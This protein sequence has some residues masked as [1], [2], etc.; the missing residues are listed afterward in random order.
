MIVG[1]VAV[2]LVF[3]SVVL[4]EFRI[5]GFCKAATIE[6]TAYRFVPW[7][8]AG[9]AVLAFWIAGILFA[10]GGLRYIARRLRFDTLSTAASARRGIAD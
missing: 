10:A 4:I 5:L 9:V 6:A 2:A 7:I 1:F 8:F 3:S